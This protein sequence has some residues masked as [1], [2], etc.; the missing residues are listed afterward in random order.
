M[1]N[2]ILW[3]RRHRSTRTGLW[4]WHVYSSAGCY[5]QPLAK[6]PELAPAIFVARC[7]VVQSLRW[8]AVHL[9]CGAMMRRVCANQQHRERHGGVTLLLPPWHPQ[10]PSRWTCLSPTLCLMGFAMKGIK[11]KGNSRSFFAPKWACP[12]FWSITENICTLERRNI[13]DFA[14]RAEELQLHLYI[15]SSLAWSG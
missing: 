8:A 4:L 12:R 6:W 10:S 9:P 1:P 3:W 13:K 7:S 11:D 2:C 14:C 5:F 15:Y